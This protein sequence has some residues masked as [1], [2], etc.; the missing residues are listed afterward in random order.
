MPATSGSTPKLLVGEERRPLG[1]GQELDDR[2]FAQE[3][4][5]LERRGRAM[6]PAVVRT[7]S[8]CA[9]EQQPLDDPFE[10]RASVIEPAVY[11]P[12]SFASSC[13]MVTPTV[14]A[15]REH[16][17]ERPL[18]EAFARPARRP[19]R[20]ADVADLAHQLLGVLEVE[21]DELLHLGPLGAFFET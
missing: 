17:A 13:S 5:R 20:Q 3:R 21:L 19:R 10:R 12:L 4:E 15:A 11:C 7:D 16:R 2:H 9:E 8:S 18:R 1:A 14:F 6:M